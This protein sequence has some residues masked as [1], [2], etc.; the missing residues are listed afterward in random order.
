MYRDQ[1]SINPHLNIQPITS[2]KLA[3]TMIHFTY[4]EGRASVITTPSPVETL[5]NQEESH[6]YHALPT[7]VFARKQSLKRTPP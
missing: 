1:K 4:L 3:H 7:L 6:A 2:C 5:L